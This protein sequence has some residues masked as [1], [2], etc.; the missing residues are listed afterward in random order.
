MRQWM[1]SHRVSLSLSLCSLSPLGLVSAS[2]Y[3][4]LS[5]SVS[6]M[7]PSCIRLILSSLLLEQTGRR[8]RTE[9]DGEG[10]RG[11]DANLDVVAHPILDE[12]RSKEESKGPLCAR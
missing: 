5:D 3:D 6:G 11:H 7:T 4:S 2:V 9:D 10:P 12:T 1:M 8:G